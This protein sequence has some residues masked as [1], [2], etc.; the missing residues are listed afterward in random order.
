ML[1]VDEGGD[2]HMFLD[3]AGKIRGMMRHDLATSGLYHVSTLYVL[4]W[5]A[6]SSVR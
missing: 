4:N 2:Y 3:T 5:T 6:R 1:S